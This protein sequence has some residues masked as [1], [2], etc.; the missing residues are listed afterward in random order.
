MEGKMLYKPGTYGT[1]VTSLNPLNIPKDLSLINRKNHD[2]TNK[3]GVPLV[4]HVKCTV[5]SPS[6][7]G[8]ADRRDVIRF[9]AVPQN[10]VYR[11]AAVK[12]HA[13][14]EKMFQKNGITKKE[15]GRYSKTIRYQWDQ[16]ETWQ[17]PLQP[18]TRVAYAT[19]ELGTWDT[20]N[21]ILSSGGS[22]DA[23]LWQREAVVLTDEDTTL[24]EVPLA[25]GY[26]TSRQVIR[27]DNQDADTIPAKFSM[28]V[29]LFD[30]GSS[31][32]NAGVRDLA[33]G[34]QDNPPYDADALQGTF[35]NPCEVGRVV[36]S[37]GTATM[38]EIYMD[39]PFGIAGIE[40]Q[41]ELG[42]TTADLEFAIEVLGVS[43]MQG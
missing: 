26:L 28:I 40:A 1:N 43:E 42:A 13:A 17:V 29:D 23:N 8:D 19:G 25:V 5:Y 36:L 11:N 24:G 10:W 30:M 32:D 38:T 27:E 12:L 33:Q 37:Q 7:A 6:Y 3:D 4:Y 14:R 15:R 35:Y 31:Q 21:L 22:V 2:H 34:E 9:L 18:D 20:T 41:S 16:A 39:I